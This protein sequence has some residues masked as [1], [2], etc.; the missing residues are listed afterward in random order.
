MPDTQEVQPSQE[1]TKLLAERH[2]SWFLET[3]KPLLIT[4]MVH[5]FKHGQEFEQLMQK[6]REQREPK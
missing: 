5:G 4:H 3:I 2:V 6:Y 1:I